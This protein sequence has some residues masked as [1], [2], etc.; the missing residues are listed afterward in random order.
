MYKPKEI[1][2]NKAQKSNLSHLELTKGK[3]SDIIYKDFLVKI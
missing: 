3:K 2:G 1:R